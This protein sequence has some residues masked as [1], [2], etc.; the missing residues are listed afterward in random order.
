MEPYPEPHAS[1]LLA[2]SALV[3]PEDVSMVTELWALVFG[4]DDDVWTCAQAENNKAAFYQH[5]LE[6]GVPISKARLDAV[7]NPDVKSAG[8]LKE[9]LQVQPH[10]SP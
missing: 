8:T 1:A 5:L 10:P 9:D 7:M 4:V 3:E 2:V 6:S